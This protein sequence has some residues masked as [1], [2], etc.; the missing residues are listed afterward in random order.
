MGDYLLKPDPADP[1][2]TNRVTGRDHEGNEVETSA[3]GHRHSRF[4]T[5]SRNS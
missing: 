3:R 2:L 1:Q 5:Q 4:L